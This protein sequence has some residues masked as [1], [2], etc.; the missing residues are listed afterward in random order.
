MSV[1]CYVAMGDSF[2]A[3]NEPGGALI[4]RLRRHAAGP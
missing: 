3:G 2:T 4:H 1:R